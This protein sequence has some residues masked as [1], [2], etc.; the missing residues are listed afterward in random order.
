MN[1]NLIKKRAEQKNIS[2]AE[3]ARE[4]KISE[5]AIHQFVRKNNC[6]V[7]DLEKI[8]EVLKVSPA[9]WW[10]EKETYT[11]LMEPM[12]A[13]DGFKGNLAEIPHGL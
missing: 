4:T 1:F 8:S 13:S 10:L 12:L 5:Q 7:Q 3:L 9:Y 6:K 2:I 11:R